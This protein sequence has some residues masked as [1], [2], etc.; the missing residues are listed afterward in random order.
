VLA[1]WAL[2]QGNA[3]AWG[4]TDS[5]DDLWALGPISDRSVPWNLRLATPG[6]QSVF[7]VIPSDRSDGF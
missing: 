7:G 6:S 5:D 1:S 2:R 4:V 3:P